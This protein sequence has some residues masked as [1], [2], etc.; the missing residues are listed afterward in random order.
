MFIAQIQFEILRKHDV[1]KQSDTI[2]ALLI[3]LSHEGRILDE[4][5][6]VFQK[7]GKFFT[8]VKIPEKD[9]FKQ[10][11]KNKYI[12][13]GLNK[14][15]EVGLSEPHFE[16]LGKDSEFSESCHCKTPSAFLLFTNFLSIQSPVKC[17]DCL[18]PIP[19]YRIKQT[20]P[21]QLRSA[22][23]WQN[24]YKACDLLQMHCGYSE[25]FGISQLSKPT[26]GLSMLGLEICAEIKN[27]TNK[28]CYYYLY[29]ANGKSL[30]QEKERKC[31]KCGGAWL[32]AEPFNGFIDFRCD[33]CHLLSNIAFSLR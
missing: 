3:D 16:I 29:R 17:F 11:K 26:S 22:L 14:L 15:G 12:C 7:T 8:I 9:A 33:R 13:E 25:R 2:F 21:Q 20:E 4:T 10:I 6:N 1:E 18:Y 19:L 24:E 27:L 5:L 23:G 32:L 28:N 31:P 30:K